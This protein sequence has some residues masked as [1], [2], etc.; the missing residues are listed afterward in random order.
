MKQN[1]KKGFSLIEIIVAVAILAVL[2]A[3]LV[4][5]YF[6]LMQQSRAKKDVTK[7]ESVCTA[8]KT[9]LGEPEVKK[10]IESVGGTSLI[11]VSKVEDNGIVDF[12]KSEVIGLSSSDISK[13]ELWANTYQTIGD[14][15]ETESVDL[16]GQYVIF[17]LKPKTASTVASCEYVVSDK[18]PTLQN[19]TLKL[20]SYSDKDSASTLVR[21][22]AKDGFS[23]R[24]E[25]EDSIY[26]VYVGTYQ[27][28]Q[29]AKTIEQ[30][31]TNSGYVAA[32][33][34]LN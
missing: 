34:L 10:E 23:A 14:S 1:N 22:L 26:T 31:L 28:I 15:Y 11:V 30:K 12:S 9:A 7:F 16:I 21:R 18:K 19:C 4:P 17:Y 27:S 20:G 8:F 29:D 2:T 6:H 24:I 33:V 32:I 13:S 3:F 25:S 5:S